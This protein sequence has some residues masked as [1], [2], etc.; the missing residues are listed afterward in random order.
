MSNAKLIEA[1]IAALP[2]VTV[3]VVANPNGKR[4]R[5]ETGTPAAGQ[6]VYAR[7]FLKSSHADLVLDAAGVDG[8]AKMPAAGL[9]E[10]ITSTATALGAPWQTE[11]E[12]IGAAAAAVAAIVYKV[13]AARQAGGL[14]EINASYKRYRQ[15]Q[16]AKAERVVPY[17]AYLQRYTVLMVE[18][19]ARLE[20]TTT[21]PR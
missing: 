13:E 20:R 17:S 7:V 1:Y 8:W 11:E 19:V 15:Q 5:I 14:K 2:I 4:A 3:S 16:V 21:S 12:I 18:E 6:A 9:L 10:L